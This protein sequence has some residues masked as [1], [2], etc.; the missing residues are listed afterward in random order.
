VADLCVNISKAIRNLTG[1]VLS[2][3]IRENMDENVRYAAEILARAWMPSR[4][5]REPAG[6]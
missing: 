1:K 2:P 3:W 5:G 6:S 4:Q